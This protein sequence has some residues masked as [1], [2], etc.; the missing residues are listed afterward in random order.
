MRKNISSLVGCLVVVFTSANAEAQIIHRDISPDK[1]INFSDY[2]I[3]VAT[4]PDSCHL[5][6]SRNVKVSLASGGGW[7][8]WQSDAQILVDPLGRALALTIGQ[9]VDGTWANNGQAILNNGVGNWIS[10]T[11]KYLGVR[12]R[13]AG[14]WFTGWVRMD[15]G[16]NGTYGVV[17]DY[18]FNAQPNG[19]ITAGQVLTTSVNKLENTLDDVALYSFN[20]SLI[21]KGIKS[22]AEV[23]VNGLDGKTVYRHVLSA[24]ATIALPALSSGIY[25]VNLRTDEGRKATRIFI[26]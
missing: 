12:V 25:V 1:V 11:N 17:K 18:A 15:V 22:P 13:L 10:V 6:P 4:S 23:S 19:S 8:Y 16:A 5:Y 14:Q 24:D 7:V 26:N 2:E 21:V 3:N 9:P 20:K